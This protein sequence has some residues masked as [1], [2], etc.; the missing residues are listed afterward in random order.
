MMDINRAFIEPWTQRGAILLSLLCL[1]VGIGGGWLLRAA[2]GRG[3]V[4]AQ[5]GSI[6]VQAPG[7]PTPASQTSSATG[8][9]EMADA[10]AAPL[11]EKLKSDPS[12]PDLLISVGN[13]YYD[14][15]QYPIAIGYYERAL[16]TRPADAA[17]RTDLGT[18]Y[19]YLGNAD[20][21]LREFNQ[22]L[23]DAPN[24]SNT[25][26][27]RGLVR[28]QGKEDRAGATADWEKL[29]ATN[30]NY[31]QRPKVEEMLGEVRNQPAG[32]SG[33]SAN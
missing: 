20:A 19:W 8:L 2:Q 16:K 11:L 24:N 4:T 12:Q 31:E 5:T 33:K 14:A 25:L 15:Q 3:A 18:A 21:A 32:G 13:L 10:Q 30:P 27:N 7:V 1:G 9:K 23:K 29:L 17:V 26:F 6:A 22:A 28:W